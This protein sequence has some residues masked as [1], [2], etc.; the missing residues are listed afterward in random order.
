[1]YKVFFHNPSRE[2]QYERHP[3]EVKYTGNCNKEQSIN[4]IYLDALGLW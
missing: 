1:M 4:S 2:I 3:N